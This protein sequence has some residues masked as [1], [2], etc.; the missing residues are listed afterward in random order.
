MAGMNLCPLQIRKS[1][2]EASAK[3]EAFLDRLGVGLPGLAISTLVAISKSSNNS[4][5]VT[6]P[7][8]A[9]PEGCEKWAGV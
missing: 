9:V 4:I 1:L 5:H 8:T 7:A 6:P 3:S 2:R